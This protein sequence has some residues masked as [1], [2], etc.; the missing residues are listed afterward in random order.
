MP[1]QVSWRAD[2]ELIERARRRAR[3]LN[4]SLNAYLTFVVDTATNP[5]A[6]GTEAE[7][8]RARF[9]AAG[10]LATTP[11]PDGPLPSS[12]EVARARAALAA[13]GGPSLSELVSEGRGE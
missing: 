2:E 6:A 11:M 3:E 8:L 4:K 1:T 7:R 9:A 13:A 10:L 5:D 12:D